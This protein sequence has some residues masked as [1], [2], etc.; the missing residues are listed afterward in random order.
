MNK[1]HLEAAYV[2]LHAGLGVRFLYTFRLEEGDRF[3]EMY[4]NRTPPFL[5]QIIE[6]RG[7]VIRLEYLN[8]CMK[9]W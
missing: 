9:H 2:G 5:H 6:T 4:K 7:P 1:Q 8:K 3:S